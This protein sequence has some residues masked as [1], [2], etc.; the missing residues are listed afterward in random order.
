MDY[1]K[2]AEAYELLEE[3]G[4]GVSATVYRAKCIPLE[5]TVAVK[6]LDLER[7]DP[8]NLEEI[9][10]E[11]QTMRMMSHP[12]LVK[13]Y[14]SFVT[15]QDLWLVMP[16]CEGGSC[17]NLIK[18]EHTKG[19]D[20]TTIATILKGVLQACEYCHQNQLIHRDIKAGNILVD[21]DGTVKLADFGVSASCWG[22]QDW[23]RHK[24]FIG[25]PCWMAPEVMDQK[26][27]YDSAAD[28][29]SLGI[30]ILELAHGHAPFAKQP[31]LKVLLMT[32]QNDPPK[33]EDTD[34]KHFSRAMREL[35]A[36]C[37]QKEP[38]KRPTATKLLDHKFLKEAKKKEYLRKMLLE[39]A[40][41][42]RWFRFQCRNPST[43]DLL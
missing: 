5:E 8:K 21:D 14:C 38:S 35:V 31:P 16:Y 26:S 7:Q 20:E 2:Y 3:V 34:K 29:W 1:P 12:N 19:F 41:E 36:A 39:G 43:K 22:T 6:V 40:C 25:T 18:W 15:K 23:Q 11:T 24:T 37:L 9:R 13:I 33:L 27:G 30:T 17:L 28:I 10:R 32:L 4:N 42:F